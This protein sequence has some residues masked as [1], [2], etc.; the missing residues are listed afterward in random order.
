M[1]APIALL[2]DYDGAALYGLAKFSKDANET[3][4]LLALVVIY[5]GGRRSEAVTA[6]GV[7][8]Q[9]IRDWECPGATPTRCGHS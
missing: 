8:M 3:R 9:I 2:P 5:N 7:G 6:G 1:A 4:R